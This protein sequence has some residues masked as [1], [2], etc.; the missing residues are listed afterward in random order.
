MII[1]SGIVVAKNAA[2]NPARSDPEEVKCFMELRKDSVSN[3]DV[4]PP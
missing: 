1:S 3:L 2:P 4:L